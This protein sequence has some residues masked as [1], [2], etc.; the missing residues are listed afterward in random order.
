MSKQ[1]DLT[2]MA[3]RKPTYDDTAARGGS[4]SAFSFRNKIINGNFEL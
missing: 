2:S 3:E 4:S 1:S